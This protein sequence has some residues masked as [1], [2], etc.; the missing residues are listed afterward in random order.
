MQWFII[1]LLLMPV[2]AWLILRWLVNAE[3]RQIMRVLRWLG[4]LLGIVLVGFAA[5]AGLLGMVVTAA[6][7]LLPL[8]FRWRVLRNILK[9]ARG[10]TP[11]Q[12]SE[13]RTRFIRMR[14]DHDTGDM[15]GMVCEG[16]YSGRVLSS[17]TFRE[18][19]DLYQASAADAQSAQVLQAYL[20]RMHGEAWQ[21]HMAAGGSSRGA[22]PSSSAGPM[23]REEARAILGVGHDAGPDAIKQA[24]RRLMKQVHPDHGGSDYLAARINEAKEVLLE[25]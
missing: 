14:L 22:G 8:I 19:L 12:G 9:T 15:D 2:A 11:G 21:A 25:E 20:E 3:P 4:L 16:P 17:M 18:L 6:A 24:H 5:R 23:S 7:L 1:L 10:P 13:V